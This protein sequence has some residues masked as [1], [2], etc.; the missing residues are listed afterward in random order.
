LVSALKVPTSGELPPVAS[1]TID[2]RVLLGCLGASFAGALLASAAPLLLLARRETADLLRVN[3]N[4]GSSLRPVWGQ[5]TYDALLV[6]QTALTLTLLVGAGLT[7]WSFLRMVNVDLGFHP[8][9]VVTGQVNLRSSPYQTLEQRLVLFQAALDE[10]RSIPGVSVAALASGMPLHGGVV[11]RAQIQGRSGQQP[12]RAWV[13]GVTADYF[14]A[15][16]IDIVRGSG[17]GSAGRSDWVLV[18]ETAARALL[19]GEDVLEKQIG[20]PLGRSEWTGSIVGIVSPTRMALVETP[21]PTIYMPLT[22][23]P[24]PDLFVVARGSGAAGDLREAVRTAMQ[25]A[26]PTLVVDGT[27]AMTDWLRLL[28]AKQRFYALLLAAFAVLAL[29]L[30]AVGTFGAA[31]YAVAQRTREIGL[32]IAL[33]ADSAKVVR[34]LM[35]RNLRVACLG[36]TLGALLAV[37]TTSVLRNLLFEVKPADPVVLS[38]VVA[39]LLTVSAVATYMPARRAATADPMTAMRA[40]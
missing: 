38:A 37:G 7:G 15:L 2:V 25:R 39:M 27:S 4:S 34:L 16:G 23:W 20:L 9:N 33:G 30:A 12:T 14:T 8:V 36:A 29:A 31:S 32:R 28:Q 6:M 22:A 1:V 11:G 17:P 10:L 26:D 3:G 18:D 5:R 21:R 24:G 40:E 35:V 19:Q 13:V